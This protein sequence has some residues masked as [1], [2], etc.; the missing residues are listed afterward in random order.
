MKVQKI[1]KNCIR[2]GVVVALSFAQV[3]PI[4]SAA[5]SPFLVS[6]VREPNDTFYREQWYL[7]HIGA[8]EAWGTTLGFEGVVVAVIDSGVDVTHP[9]L[10]Q[11]I[12][13]N[14]D[15][16][17]GD[18]LDNDL[19]GFVDDVQGWDFVD[20][21][22]NPAPEFGT[23]SEAIA[24]SHGTISA[25][26]I[27]ARGDNNQGLSGVTWQTQIMP[28]R[29][30]GSDGNGLTFSVVRAMDYAVTNGA[31]IINL[32]F[33]GNVDDS[34][35]RI[36]AQRA[37]D[38][39]VV[40]IASA[41]N[42]PSGGVAT[43]LNNELVNP[44]CLDAGFSESFVIG[45]AATDEEDRRAT[46][47]NYG[48]RCIDVSAPGVRFV[49]TQLFRPGTIFG[50]AYGGFYN[51]TSLAAP[52]VSGV[53]A[54][55][56]SV[57]MSLNPEQVVSILKSTAVSIDSK[58]PEFVGML[59]AGRVNAAAAVAESL[60]LVQG[61]DADGGV[62]PGSGVSGYDPAKEAA[63][64]PSIAINQEM[65]AMP[66]EM[67]CAPGSLVKLPNDRNP[68]TQIDTAVY[69]CGVDGKR[70]VFPNTQTYFTWYADFSMV[71]EVSLEM[72]S[73]LPIGGNVTARPGVRMLKI[74]SDPRV[75]V[76]ARGGVLRPVANE[77][78]A[79]LLYGK[80]WAKKVFDLSDAFFVNYRL[81]ESL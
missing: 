48:S 81:G 55:M 41:G 12:W 5:F 9:D 26:I 30:L 8:P 68:E 51:G 19:N 76:V 28:L 49:A 11:N 75:Y 14:S 24:A 72:L 80:D 50:E 33:A 73:S 62:V 46:F 22:S 47:S 77:A 4:A 44:V 16:I 38:N 74:Q 69:Y 52:V 35:L 64:A 71:K 54:L 60:R 78:Q 45:V 56:L 57:N 3:S 36:A 42:A 20:N 39:G 15:E 40:V 17:P 61:G 66:G 43:N 32:S 25:G 67:V 53:V 10:Q 21:D 63:A 34:L 79:E 13:R 65:F 1:L 23:D 2:I 29:A 18:G 37:Y 59:G 58:N 31:K 6:A 7:P 27:A 70:Y